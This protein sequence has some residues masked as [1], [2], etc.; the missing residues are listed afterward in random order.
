MLCGDFRL[1]A[2]MRRKS[3]DPKVDGVYGVLQQDYATILVSFL[4][5]HLEGPRIFNHF[6]RRG[7]SSGVSD[8]VVG[9]IVPKL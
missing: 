8:G 2:D 6:V 3:S 4:S 9:G 7:M 5:E 1:N